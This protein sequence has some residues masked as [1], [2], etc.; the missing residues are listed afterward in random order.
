M[1]SQ[2][3]G[4]VMGGVALACAMTNHDDFAAQRHGVGDP[5]VVRGLFRRTLTP[6][7]PRL[8]LVLEMMQ[9]VMRIVGS[10]DVFRSLIGHDIDMENLCPVMIDD[11]Q[12]IWRDRIGMGGGLGR[13]LR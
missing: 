7:F 11:D 12:E 2:I 10:D 4:E 3:F 1:R 6:S 9:E 8:I 5:R 13:M